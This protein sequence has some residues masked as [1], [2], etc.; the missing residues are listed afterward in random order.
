MVKTG[1][2]LQS[3]RASVLQPHSKYDWRR[4]QEPLTFLPTFL[5]TGDSF[6]VQFCCFP[7][8]KPQHSFQ[9]LAHIPVF[10]WESRRTRGSDSVL[11]L[12]VRKRMDFQL[13]HWSGTTGN[14][15]C[16][17]LTDGYKDTLSAPQNP[18]ATC[19]IQTWLFSSQSFY[20]FSSCLCNHLPNT[21]SAEKFFCS[22]CNSKNNLCLPWFSLHIQTLS[23]PGSACS[24]YRQ[25]GVTSLWVPGEAAPSA[26]S[27]KVHWWPHG[28]FPIPYS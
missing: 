18:V 1:H 25:K 10:W 5:T 27:L 26:R 12:R 6:Y 20:N 14:V 9:P 4:G 22:P 13:W 7:R 28:F 23:P 24:Q 3:C 19:I 21:V 11:T 8:D 16:I 2:S 15:K 17:L